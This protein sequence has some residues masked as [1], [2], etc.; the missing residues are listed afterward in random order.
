[1]KT[2]QLRLFQFDELTEQGKAKAIANNADYNV[3]YNWW[4]MTYEDARNIGLKIT[5]FDLDRA[6]YCNAEFINDAIYTARQTH[7]QHGEQT[8]TYRIATDF[9]ESRDLIVTTWPKDETGEFEQAD[10]LDEALDN[11]EDRFLKSLAHAYLRILDAE[12]D[13]LTSDEAIAEALTANEYWFTANGK[14][15]THLEKLALTA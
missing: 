4:E 8:D 11:C 14:M 13:F 9:Q 5:G 1:M 2:I 7:L 12:Y 3:S 15:A 6:H 10:E